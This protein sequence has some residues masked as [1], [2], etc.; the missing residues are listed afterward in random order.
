ML[1]AINE[2]HLFTLLPRPLSLT[3]IPFSF[4]FGES[5]RRGIEVGERVRDRGLELNNTNI[6]F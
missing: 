5:T 2:M 1:S 3:P 6:L 4:S